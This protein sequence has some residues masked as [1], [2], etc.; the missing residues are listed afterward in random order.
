[1]QRGTWILIA[2]YGSCVVVLGVLA[3]FVFGH[4]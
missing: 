1:M 2:W 4:P 3:Y